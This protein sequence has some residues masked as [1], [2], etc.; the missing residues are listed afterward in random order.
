MV[1]HLNTDKPDQ[2]A[3]SLLISVAITTTVWV[4]V[5]FATEPESDEVLEK[6]YRKV[7]PEGPGWKVV[8]QQLGM[9]PGESLWPTAFNWFCGVVLVYGSLF[10]IGKL[11]FKDWLAGGLYLGIAAFSGIVLLRTF[12]GFSVTSVPQPAAEE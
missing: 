1:F 5:T 8:A 9:P 10:G 11:I 2:F 7:H 12:K 4:I 3:Q 6:F